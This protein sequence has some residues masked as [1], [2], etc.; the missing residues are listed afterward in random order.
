MG[1]TGDEMTHLAHTPDVPL[2]HLVLHQHRPVCPYDFHGTRGHHKRLVVRAVFLR[3]LSHQACS[4][5]N[6]WYIM[7][8]IINNIQDIE[9]YIKIYLKCIII[10]GIVL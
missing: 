2:L 1:V 3:F 9:K 5:I 4:V 10:N 7:T 8:Y 6:E